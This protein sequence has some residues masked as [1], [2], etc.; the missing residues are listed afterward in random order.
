MTKNA[1]FSI[2]PL[3]E[4]L[5]LLTFCNAIEDIGSVTGRTD[6]QKLRLY[7]RTDLKVEIVI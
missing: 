4:H 6:G 1:Y 3:T 5:L 7:G 2:L